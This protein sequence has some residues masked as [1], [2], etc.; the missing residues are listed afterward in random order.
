MYPRYSF[1]IMSQTVKQ[2][3]DYLQVLAKCNPKQRQAI[4]READPKLIKAICECSLNVI[5][6]NIPLSPSQ[7]QKLKPHKTTL[8]S[9]ADKNKSAKARKRLIVQ[10]GGFVGV[11]LRA[12]I[13]TLAS[14]LLK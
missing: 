10:R 3:C 5:K 6:G 9:L 2:C 4:L 13:P 8:R 11:L 1:L 14:L 12:I 7:K